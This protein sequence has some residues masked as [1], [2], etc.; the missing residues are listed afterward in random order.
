[1]VNLASFSL[2]T[3]REVNQGTLGSNC[4]VYH[5]Y[6]YRKRKWEMGLETNG[7]DRRT[8]EAPQ[9]PQQ[10]RLQVLHKSGVVSF[11]FVF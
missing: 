10:T 11:L 2:S 5:H 3:V 1:M 6:Q 7:E 8:L 4:K 9:W